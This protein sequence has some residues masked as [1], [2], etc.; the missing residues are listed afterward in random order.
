M[1]PPGEHHQPQPQSVENSELD[2]KVDM[3]L[4][5]ASAA[6]AADRQFV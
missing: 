5:I 4:E 6:P 2:Q 1:W 3:K